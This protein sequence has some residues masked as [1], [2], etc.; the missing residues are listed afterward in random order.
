MS[1]TTPQTKPKKPIYKKWWFWLIA[2]IVVIAIANSGKKSV[3]SNETPSNDGNIVKTEANENKKE[4]VEEAFPTIGESL[5]TDYFQITLN[6]A[7]V[8][9]KVNTGNQFADLDEEPGNKFLI[10]DITFKNIDDESRMF[11]DGSVYI[12]FNGK[13]Y[14][15][16]KSETIMLKGWGTMLDRI[17]PLT[18]KT[19]KLVYKIPT[20]ISGAVYWEP[21]RNYDDKRFFCGNL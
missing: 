1:E 10:L 7:N 4:E 21:G 3:N 19:T 2:V 6:K 17:N 12:N 15:Y 20:E 9:T 16:D 11:I 8:D 18:T 14:K 13:E 5:S